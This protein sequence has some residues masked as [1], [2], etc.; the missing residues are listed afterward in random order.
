MTKIDQL[1]WLKKKTLEKYIHYKY[2]RNKSCCVTLA[3]LDI[4]NVCCTYVLIGGAVKLLQF[5]M[6]KNHI[7][8]MHTNFVFI[9]D[10]FCTNSKCF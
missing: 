9:L 5:G 7:L 10:A 4:L 1:G 6:S 2:V 8:N 3:D